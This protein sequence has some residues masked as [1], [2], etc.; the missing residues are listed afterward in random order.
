M[1]PITIAAAKTATQEL[2]KLTIGKA[3]AFLENRYNLNKAEKFKSNFVD[4]YEKLL[5]IRTLASQERKLFIDEIYVPLTIN[6]EGG[7]T[8]DVLDSTLLDVGN[9]AKVIKGVAGQGKSTILKKLLINNV[10]KTEKLPIFYELKNYRGGSLEQAIAESLENY[11]VGLTAPAISKILED[12][13]VKLYLDAF[14]EVQPDYRSELLDEISRIINTSGCHILCTTRPETELETLTTLQTYWVKNLTERQIF[15]IIEKVCIDTEKATELCESLKKSHLYNNG[16]SAL[17]TPILVTLYSISYNLGEEI[18]ESLSQFYS[19]IFET[20]F[21]RHDN[22]K[23]KVNRQRHWNENRK[24]YREIFDYMCFSTQRTGL[25]TFNRDVLTDHTSKALSYVG[26]STKLTDKITNELISITNLIIEDGY[27][28]YRFIH[29]SI[30]EFFSSSLIRSLDSEKK[31]GFYKKCLCSHETS[32]IFSNTLKFLKETD[33][34]DYAEH[35]LI[36]GISDLLSL[37]LVPLDTDYTPTHELIEDFLDSSYYQLNITSVKAKGSNPGKPDLDLSPILFKTDPKISEFKSRLFY[38]ATK[39][40]TNKPSPEEARSIMTV[41]G[42][43]VETGTYTADLRIFTEH[44]NLCPQ[45]IAKTLALSANLSFAK[46]YNHAL[47]RI[48]SRKQAIFSDP[49]LDF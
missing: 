20:I 31:L 3:Y 18:P 15:S 29:K 38:L 28:E 30:Q 36:V 23:G 40:I 43:H 21:F 49:I 37:D 35:Y 22:L 33:Y 34:Y 25:L 44:T 7:L 26:E 24:I 6:E 2:L 39:L 5:Y 17:R 8:F 32:T 9:R 13:T 48:D 16:E 27:N 47:Q 12:S 4:Y 1:D 41:Y 45:E 11:G 42:K 46:D 14:D 10:R 19:N